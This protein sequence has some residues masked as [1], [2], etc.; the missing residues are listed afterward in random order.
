MLF[1]LSDCF[2]NITVIQLSSCTYLLIYLP[3]CPHLLVSASLIFITYLSRICEI[4][5]QVACSH[6]FFRETK[7]WPALGMRDSTREVFGFCQELL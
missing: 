2:C 1:F 3:V 6:L 7:T 4:Y 5:G